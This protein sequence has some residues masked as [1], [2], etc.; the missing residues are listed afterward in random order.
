MAAPLANTRPSDSARDAAIA[1]LRALLGD[2]VSTA[3][4]VR[5]Q[6]GKDESYHPSV[7]PD[8]VAFARSTDEVSAIVKICAR[9]KVPIIPY[10][11]GTSLEGQVAALHGGVCVDVMQ[12]NRVL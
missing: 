6:H 3:A 8:A 10:G 7:P 4:A 9:H 1:E 2:R 12:M 11:T 5:E